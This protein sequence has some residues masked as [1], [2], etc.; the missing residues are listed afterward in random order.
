MALCIKLL[1]ALL[2]DSLTL[3]AATT[4]TSHAMRCFTTTTNPLPLPSAWDSAYTSDP[5][6]AT[7]LLLEG[8]KYIVP[9]GA[10]ILIYVDSYLGE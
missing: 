1:S 10:Y 7:L 3:T 9:V 8:V 6:T 4:A 2:Q 5:T